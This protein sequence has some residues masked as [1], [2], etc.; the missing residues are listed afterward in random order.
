MRALVALMCCLP[1]LAAAGENSQPSDQQFIDKAYSINKGEIALGKLAQHRGTSTAVRD[2]GARLERDHQLGLDRL[3]ETAHQAHLIMPTSIQ[4]EESDL[5]TQLQRLRGKEF[6][7]AF[8]EH[9]VHGHQEAISLFENQAN[10]GQNVALRNYA[11]ELLPILKQ[12][13]SIAK[14]DLA[15]M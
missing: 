8:I 14:R 1:S 10:Q 15:R 5:Y 12:H 7:E 3:R 2:F 6:D 9:M 11:Q 13:E 4:R